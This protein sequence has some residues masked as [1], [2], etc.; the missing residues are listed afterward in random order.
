[1]KKE[2]NI[3]KISLFN[4]KIV[5]IIARGK[6]AK[7]L[8]RMFKRIESGEYGVCKYCKEEIGKKRLQARPVASAC[9]KCKTKL[10]SSI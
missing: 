6:S 1:M 7:A 3:K 5:F 8:W 4:G 10:Q 9:V 2:V